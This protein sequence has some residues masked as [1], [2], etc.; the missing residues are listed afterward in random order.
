M[1]RDEFPVPYSAGL[2]LLH[3]IGRRR[4]R[5]AAQLMGV[6]GRFVCLQEREGQ[7]AAAAGAPAPP[8]AIP[9][10][11]GVVAEGEGGVRLVTGVGTERPT[12]DFNLLLKNGQADKAFSGMQVKVG[13]T[14]HR[15]TSES[16]RK[17]L[18]RTTSATRNALW[19]PVRHCTYT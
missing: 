16:L 13:S 18:S 1:S 9:A 11:A 8:A 4:C 15:V 19:A 10:A 7:A 2:A 3:P 14:L 17:L 12:E 5:V 6:L